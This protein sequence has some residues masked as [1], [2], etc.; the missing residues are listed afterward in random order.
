MV[1]MNQKTDRK[2]YLPFITKGFTAL[3]TAVLLLTSIGAPAE[4]ALTLKTEIFTKVPSPG[5]PEGVTVST[6]DTVYVGTHQSATNPANTPSHVF[7]YDKSGNLKRDY[8]IQGQ[9]S[10]GQ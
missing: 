6:D 2:K 9:D 4:A 7:A 8:V 3:A 5:F 1:Q 10:S